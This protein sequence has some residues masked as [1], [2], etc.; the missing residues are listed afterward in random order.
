[1][2][3]SKREKN[4]IVLLV[5]AAAVYFVFKFVV[6]PQLLSIDQAKDNKA[7]LEKEIQMLSNLSGLIED[8][9]AEL[10][11][12]ETEIQAV[13]NRYFGALGK[14]EET[15][16]VLTELFRNT[17]C[18]DLTINLEDLSVESTGKVSD[19]ASE[20]DQTAAPSVQNVSLSYEGS[21]AQ[22]WN[23][24]RAVWEFPKHI[25]VT[26]ITITNSGAD[27]DGTEVLSG[28]IALSLYDFSGMTGVSGGLVR[29]FENGAFRKSNPFTPRAEEK[30]PGTRYELVEDDAVLNRYVKFS[31]ISG[32]WAESAIDTF[33]TR[34]LVSGDPINR[35]FPDKNITRG[36]F[37]VLLDK[38]FQW[39]EPK[40]PIDLTTFS[41]YHELGDSLNAIEKAFYKGYLNK[42]I[43]GYGDGSLK[44]NALLSYTEF[45]LIMSRVLEQPDFDWTDASRL[46]AEATGYNSP[47]ADDKS[48]YMTKAEAVYFLD[49]LPL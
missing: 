23:L 11:S 16:I 22:L 17:G 28:D 20:E 36:E 49:T 24:L 25:T 14:Q 7:A 43:L 39:E 2:R 1:M 30:F 10:L 46:I 13:G 12:A 37:I 18:D 38:L 4:L 44:P 21:Y 9:S 47:G 29:W 33:G 8:Y 5:F 27:S 48:A 34:K 3:I 42:Y 32:H 35:F 45:E 19:T 41:D 6:T 31:D 40:E 15:I 26:D